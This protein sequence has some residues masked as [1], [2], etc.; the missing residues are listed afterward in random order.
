MILD[1]I[2]LEMSREQRIQMMK[3][4]LSTPSGEK[5]R[6]MRPVWRAVSVLK[7]LDSF[8][9]ELCFSPRDITD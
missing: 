3:E 1:Y 8:T 5:G 2:S 7:S 4:G 9:P 6:H